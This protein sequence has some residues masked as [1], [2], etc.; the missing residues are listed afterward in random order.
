MIEFWYEFAS[1]YSYPA[2]MRIEAL[3]EAAGF[4]AC[5]RCDPKG[6]RARLH[7]EAVAAACA[8]IEASETI[9]SLEWLILTN[10]KL[11]NLSVRI[12]ASV[13]P[14]ARHA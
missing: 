3:A 1:T 14:A 9:P 13:Q 7:A 12:A 2:A 5:K 6:D 4:R 8:L 10:N 11:A